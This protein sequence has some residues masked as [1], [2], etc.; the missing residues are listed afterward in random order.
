MFSRTIGFAVPFTTSDNLLSNTSLLEDEE[1]A[2]T[3]PGG[4]G[5]N[6][7]ISRSN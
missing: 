5:G 4:S 1:F 2:G 3:G 6:E 7:F